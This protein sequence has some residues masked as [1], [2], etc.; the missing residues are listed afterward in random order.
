MSEMMAINIDYI[1][2]LLTGSNLIGLTYYTSDIGYP[3][4]SKALLIP[5]SKPLS[6]ANP[7]SLPIAE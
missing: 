4:K 5:N 2:S 1:L 6:S 3:Y 7:L